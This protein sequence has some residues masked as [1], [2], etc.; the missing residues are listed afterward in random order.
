MN[1]FLNQICNVNQTTIDPKK[2]I[3]IVHFTPSFPFCHN[4]SFGL[5]TKARGCKG[6]GQE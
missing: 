3:I 6:A 2:V 5:A 4:P 1:S